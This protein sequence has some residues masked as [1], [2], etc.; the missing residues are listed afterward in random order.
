VKVI[1]GLGNPG[2]DYAGTRHNIGFE[3]IDA[4]A[5]AAGT[6]VTNRRDRAL[7]ARITLSGETVL[8]VKPQTY[9]NLSGES[10]AAILHKEAL[11]L[12]ALLVLCD[13]IHLPVGRL[14]IR[15]RGSSGGQNGLKNIAA[16]LES[17]EW[18]RLRLGVGEP[19]PGRQ[20]DWV[21][22]RFAPGDRKLMD[23]LLIAAQGVV[24]VWAKE[25]TIAAAN[26]FN[27]LDLRATP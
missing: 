13:D 7:T 15:A 23:E 16:R 9:M 18:A 12:E 14:R 19:P 1:V 27:G 11:P 10:V 26:R 6:T 3:L 22:S 4:L 21:L 24:E 8:L 25:G 5:G 17:E 2:A 20:I